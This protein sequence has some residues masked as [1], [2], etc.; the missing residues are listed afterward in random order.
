MRRAVDFPAVIFGPEGEAGRALGA[1]YE[2][3]RAVEP[4]PV[5]V[6]DDAFKVGGAEVAEF[7]VE[8]VEVKPQ[9]EAPGE[10]AGADDQDG[11]EGAGEERQFEAE[12]IHGAGAGLA[13]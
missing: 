12:G 9:G 5:G 1:G 4:L 8:A 7:A 6:P 2:A 11:G 13:R 10:G 3:Q